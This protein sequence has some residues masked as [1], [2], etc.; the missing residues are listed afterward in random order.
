MLFRSAAGIGFVAMKTLAGGGFLDRE[1][2]KPMNTTAA[3][4]WA[5]SNPDI[6][7]TIPGMT[8][9]D[10]LDLNI[11]ILADASLSDKEKGDILIAR[12]ESGLFCSGCNECL[13]SCRL[14]LPVP[15]MMRA[16]MYAYGYSNPAQAHSLL[17]ELGTGDN[18]CSDCTGPCTINCF[19]NFNIREKIT[20][21][22]RLVNV[23][24]DFLA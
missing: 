18:P 24:A 13:S 19:R 11:K 5:L 21:V 12:S 23:P 20:D 17:A 2:T 7:T 15:D 10:Q 14:N 16:F 4:K 8:T 9:F 1:K 22:S 6:H 3:I